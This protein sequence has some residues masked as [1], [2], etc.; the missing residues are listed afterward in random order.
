MRSLQKQN[1]KN[2]LLPIAIVGILVG[3]P[4]LDSLY[5]NSSPVS[6]LIENYEDGYEDDL[7]KN[8]PS[9][10]A[11]AVLSNSYM[12]IRVN[13]TYLTTPYKPIFSKV[14]STLYDIEL[15]PEGI[16]DSGD[17]LSSTGSQDGTEGYASYEMELSESVSFQDASGYRIVS[18]SSTSA[19]AAQWNYSII[20]PDTEPYFLFDLEITNIDDEAILLDEIGS[21]I[22][23]GII[24]MS[25]LRGQL[26]SDT[27][28][29]STSND[30]LYVN[31]LG[32]V[33]FA[34]TT[35][36]DSHTP[37]PT[38]PFFTMYDGST[39]E[40]FT[41]GLLEGSTSANQIIS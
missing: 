31:G 23:D 24:G 30:L 1:V 40:G 41:V 19:Y 13:E 32:N 16:D 9:T 36:W 25:Y 37:D 21:H 27:F 14:S 28:P 12:E 26:G 6:T 5:D 39:G 35:Y 17:V 4:M 20:L 8:P 2:L 38:R 3:I 33:P 7:V 15:A 29:T 34:S 18:N 11:D 10:A 22:H